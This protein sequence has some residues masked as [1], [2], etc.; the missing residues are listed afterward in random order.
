MAKKSTKAEINKRISEVYTLLT[1]AY[2]Y[3]E[4]VRYC[5]EAWGIRA[6]RTVDKY[7]KA[8]TKRITNENAKDIEQIRAEANTRLDVLYH[9]AFKEDKFSDCAYIQSIKNKING[10]DQ[11]IIQVKDDRLAEIFKKLD[12]KL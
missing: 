6:S 8:A 12:D 11:K 9:R 7:I 2:T 5:R 3:T 4:I 10:L 1:Q